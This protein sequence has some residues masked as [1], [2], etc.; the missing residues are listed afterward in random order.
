MEKSCGNCKKSLDVTKFNKKTRRSNGEQTYQSYCRL[1]SHIRFKEYYHKNR[2]YH[3][4]VIQ[5]QKKKDM[6]KTAA[7]IIEYLLEH[8]CVDCG[9]KDIRVLEFDHV[10]GKKSDSVATMRARGKSWTN[11]EKE[12]KKCDVRCANCHR[13]KTGNDFKWFKSLYI[14]NNK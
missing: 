1:C 11:I 14:D 6:A 5:R 12:I 13:I 9:N 7:K 4:A 3:C 8:S 2:E 10:R